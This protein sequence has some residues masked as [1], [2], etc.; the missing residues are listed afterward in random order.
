MKMATHTTTELWRTLAYLNDGLNILVHETESFFAQPRLNL[1]ITQW[2]ETRRLEDELKKTRA[3]LTRLNNRIAD[4]LMP[5]QLDAAGL[6]F[7]PHAYGT[8]RINH[9]FKAVQQKGKREEIHAWLGANGYGA[10]IVP[11]V[12]ARTLAAAL[13]EPF[14]QGEEPPAELIKCS[15]RRYCSFGDENAPT[16][17]E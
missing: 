7:A 6:R 2:H 4:E 14:A 17:E 3:L 9:H 5:A 13:K 15:V 16:E 10:L 12:N 11:T 8:V 1:T